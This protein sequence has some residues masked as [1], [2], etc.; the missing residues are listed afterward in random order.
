MPAKWTENQQKAIDIRNTNTLVSAA[1]GSGK[2]A[3]LVERVIQRI[4]D[5]KQPVPI[6]R[7]LIVTFTNAAAA[8]MRERIYDAL[9]QEIDRQPENTGLKQQ[10]TLLGQAQITTV[11]SFCQNL[12]RSNFHRLG[13][14]SDFEIADQATLAKFMQ[15][16][17]HLDIV[18]Y[19]VAAIFYFRC[20]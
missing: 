4:T 14:F 18:V 15:D 13:I 20:F 19:I 11:H 5:P 8:E 7:L 6:D 17:L 3:V 9:I 1:A 12:I 16:A 10:L 2:T